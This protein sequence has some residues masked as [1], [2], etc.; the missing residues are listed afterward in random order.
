MIYILGT[1]CL[2]CALGARTKPIMFNRNACVT[3]ENEVDWVRKLKN[4]KKLQILQFWCLDPNTKTTDSVV[5]VFG[6]KH[7]NYRICSFGVW[8]QTPKLQNL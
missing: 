3:F 1:V 5:L 8:I 6:S 2:F 4:E 7:Q